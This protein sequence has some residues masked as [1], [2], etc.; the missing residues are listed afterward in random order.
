MFSKSSQGLS[1]R[2]MLVLFLIMTVTSYSPASPAQQPAI[3]KENSTSTLSSSTGRYV[4]G[5]MG[6]VRQD[7]F[8]L[9]TQTGRLWILTQGRDIDRLVLDPVL[10]ITP[11]DTG[12]TLVPKPANSADVF[13]STKSTPAEKRLQND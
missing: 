9:D 1:P 12:Y 6:D 10:Y 11:G 4:F 7:T 13:E 5:R 8:M 2:F 3:K